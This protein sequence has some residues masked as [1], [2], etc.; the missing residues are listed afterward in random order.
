MLL[1]LDYSW[2][3]ASLSF[4][5][6]FF[7]MLA[8]FPVWSLT[9]TIRAFGAA[10]RRQWNR[11]ILLLSSYLLALPLMLVGM[12]WGGNYLHFLIASP[13]YVLE[14]AARGWPEQMSFPWADQGWAGQEGGQTLVYD[15]T[16]KLMSETG[17]RKSPCDP[18]AG[19]FPGYTR[20]T[21]YIWHFYLVS[22]TE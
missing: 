17:I 20:T 8:A 6:L 1:G 21:H 9:V 10:F 7:V 15:A 12:V 2:T 13:V 19:C 18:L 3:G 14:I 16:D 5:M 11:C 4:A 22:W